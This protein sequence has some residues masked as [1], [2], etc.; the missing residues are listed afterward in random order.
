[1]TIPQHVFPRC[2]AVLFFGAVNCCVGLAADRADDG[3]TVAIDRLERRDASARWNRLRRGRNEAAAMA[4]SVGLSPT[5]QRRAV[6]ENPPTDGPQPR[7]DSAP[8]KPQV[9]NQPQTR[10]A[11]GP[12]DLDLRNALERPLSP[13]REVPPAE[14]DRTPARPWAPAQT[15]TVLHLRKISEI[16]PFYDY[17]PDG[18][19]PC[20]NLCPRPKNCP[21]DGN[22]KHCPDEEELPTSDELA[23]FSEINYHWLASNLKYNPLYFEDPALERYGHTE[24]D[25]IQPTLS[26]GRF[27]VQLVGLP[28][29]MTLHPPCSC[30]SPLGYYRPGECAPKKCYQIPLNAKAA[31]VTAG[32]YTGLSFLLFP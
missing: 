30:Q 7:S 15:R 13:L 20:E 24:C 26:A 16:D 4:G 6:W 25:L 11:G 19:N 28:Y 1:M 31:I 8:R 2:A 3:G 14:E 10:V 5:P 9:T 22:R 27:A 17:S 29:Q 23:C 12:E 32:F 18:G 21:A